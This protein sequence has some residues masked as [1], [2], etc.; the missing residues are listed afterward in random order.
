MAISL[1]EARA[2]VKDSQW[3][4][5]EPIGEGGGGT[6]FLCI[7]S[8]LR[9]DLNDVGLAIRQSTLSGATAEIKDPKSVLPNL[10]GHLLVAARR[11]GGVSARAMHFRWS[12]PA[13]EAPCQ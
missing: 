9:R 4:P 6:V 11:H 3:T 8:R 12:R 2:K 5:V 7:E 1:D 10:L 13:Q